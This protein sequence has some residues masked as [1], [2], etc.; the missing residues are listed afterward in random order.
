MAHEVV[1]RPTA[2]D[3]LAEIEDWIAERSNQAIADSYGDRIIAA[4]GAL[5]DFPRRGTAREDLRPGIRTLAFER[6]ATIVYLVRSD[7]VEI[8]RI[9]RRGRDIAGAF[10]DDPQ[11]L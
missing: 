6:G 3:D 8:V 7:V 10:N 4:C 2:R 1:F 5:A 11:P 9:L